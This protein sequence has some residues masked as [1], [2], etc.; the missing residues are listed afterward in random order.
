MGEEVVLHFVAS[1]NVFRYRLGESVETFRSRGSMMKFKV[2]TSRQ[3]VNDVTSVLLHMPV[4]SRNMDYHK[5]T[6]EQD[7]FY[8][9]L[10]RTNFFLSYQK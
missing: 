2:G 1:P 7:S 6:Q 8:K 5:T 3:K 4:R 10:H 9:S